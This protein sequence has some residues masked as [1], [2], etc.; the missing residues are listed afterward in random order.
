[1]ICKPTRYRWHQ[2]TC[3]ICIVCFSFLLEKLKLCCHQ[4][5]GKLIDVVYVNNCCQF[6]KWQRMFC[7]I[8]WGIFLLPL[9]SVQIRGLPFRPSVVLLHVKPIHKKLI[10]Y[11]FK[12]T[13]LCSKKLYEQKLYLLLGYLSETTS[14]PITDY[15]WWRKLTGNFT[16]PS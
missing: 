13:D 4:Q 16:N 9:F 5:Q 1:M 11:Y 14:I 12:G 10:K 15:S 7:F 2:T 6:F 8:T 3:C